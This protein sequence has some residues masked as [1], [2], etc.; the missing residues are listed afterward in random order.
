MQRCAGYRIRRLGRKIGQNLI[1]F[2]Y[3]YRACVNIPKY[4]KQRKGALHPNF[5]FF[6][7]SRHLWHVISRDGV[8]FKHRSIVGLN[9]IPHHWSRESVTS[10]GSVLLENV[11]LHWSPIGS[12][13]L[14]GM[15]RTWPKSRDENAGF[16]PTK[17]N[18]LHWINYTKT[19]LIHRGLPQL[20]ANSSRDKFANVSGFHFLGKDRG[21][22]SEAIILRNDPENRLHCERIKMGNFW[23]LTESTLCNRTFSWRPETAM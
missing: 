10:L 3:S 13:R 1:E 6:P 17:W 4:G 7:S 23:E 18:G 9:R 20:M 21:V 22:Y 19:T 15:N 11:V 2:I 8:G 12:D 16:R 14:S 5:V